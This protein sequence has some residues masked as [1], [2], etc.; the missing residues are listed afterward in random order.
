MMLTMLCC[1]GLTAY[2]LEFA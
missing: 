1:F 2:N